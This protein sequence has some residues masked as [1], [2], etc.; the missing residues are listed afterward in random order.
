MKI[1]QIEKIAGTPGRQNIALS[2]RVIAVL[3]SVVGLASPVAAD[4]IPPATSKVY[5]QFHEGQCVDWE[6]PSSGPGAGVEDG[7]YEANIYFLHCLRRTTLPRC[8]TDIDQR[9]ITVDSGLGIEMCLRFMPGLTFG[10]N[11]S[12]RSSAVTGRLLN[13]FELEAPTTS[14]ASATLP[15]QISTEINWDGV[16]YPYKILPPSYAQITATLQVRDTTTGE[17]VA[18]N[19]FLY[20]HAA[21]VMDLRPTPVLDCDFTGDGIDCEF[22]NPFDLLVSVNNSSGADLSAQLLRGREYTVEVEARC[23]HTGNF[24]VEGAWLFAL[25]GGAF[26][27]MNCPLILTSWRAI[28][29]LTRSMM[30][31][32]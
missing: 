11:G 26:S 29:I 9:N 17:V 28:L 2:Q 5:T 30:D 23:E 16:L 24:G 25:P 18:S 20:E 4:I 8:T 19:T 12:T 3:L 1:N 15:V 21:S 10:T 14:P 6:V 31:L 22:A 7:N 13:R 32:P 27:V